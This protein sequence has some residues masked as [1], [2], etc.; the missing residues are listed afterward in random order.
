MPMTLSQSS[1]NRFVLLCAFLQ[2]LGLLLM[3]DWLISMSEPGAY[4]AI[5]WPLYTI[6]NILPLSLMMLAHVP[7]NSAWKLTLSFTGVAAMCAAYVGHVSYVKGLPN[8]GASQYYCEFG[9]CVAL[10]WF[11]ALAFAEHYCQF[12]HWASRYEALFEFSWR[13]TV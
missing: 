12:K 10:T 13:N 5:T 2:G 7:R 4:Y 6:I 11:I 3:H 8:N 9:F 1:S